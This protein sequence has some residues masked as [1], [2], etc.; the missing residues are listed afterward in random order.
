M[1]SG[2]V[3]NLTGIWWPNGKIC[4]NDAGRTKLFFTVEF[5]SKVLKPQSLTSKEVDNASK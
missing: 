1:Q 2:G 3:R 4:R 5:I